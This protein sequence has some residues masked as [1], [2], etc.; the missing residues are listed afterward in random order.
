MNILSIEKAGNKTQFFLS[1]L[2]WRYLMYARY[3][4]QNSA[5]VH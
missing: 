5:A 4:T 2:L 1:F 3:H